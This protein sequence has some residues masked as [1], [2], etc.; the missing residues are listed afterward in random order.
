M[1]R[2]DQARWMR[3][4]RKLLLPGVVREILIVEASA[5]SWMAQAVL[6]GGND[7]RFRFQHGVLID[8]LT[9][10]DARVP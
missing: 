5:E 9:V 2:R 8:E 6:Y 1:D 4:I 3:R 7:R 10:G